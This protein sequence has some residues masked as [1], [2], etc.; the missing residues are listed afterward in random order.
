MDKQ[1]VAI[2][3]GGLGA[4]TT[5]YWLSES[6]QASEKYEITIY[7]QGW[8]LGGKGASGRNQGEGLGQRIEEHG[9]HIWFG[10]YE[11][12]FRTYR[13]VLE[14]LRETPEPKPATYQ[15]WREAFHPHSLVVLGDNGPDGLEQ[16]PI[17]FARNDREPGRGQHPSD[18]GMFLEALQAGMNFFEGRFGDDN[19]IEDFLERFGLP[20]WATQLLWRGERKLRRNFLRTVH[21]A[22]GLLPEDPLKR[23]PSLELGLAATLELFRNTSREVLRKKIGSRVR[24]RR[25]F[26]MTDLLATT[27][28][29]ILRDSLMHRGFESVD[30]LE[31]RQWLKR[32]GAD[33]EHT[34]NSNFTRVLNDLMFAYAGGD[35]QQPNI[36][37]GTAAR[38]LLLALSGY[39]GAFMYKM[40]SGMGDTL[41]VPMYGLLKARGVKFE[42][43]HRVDKIWPDANG[44]IEQIDMSR[45]VRLK[46]AVK[47]AGGYAPLKRVGAYDTWPSTPDFS[48]IINGN[49][50]KQD[51]DN[52]GQPYNLE[53]GWTAWPGAGSRKL[54]RGK[55]FDL[56]VNAIPPAGQETISSALIARSEAWKKMFLGEARVQTTRTQAMQLWMRK[57]P[58]EMGWR[59]P[60][61]MRLAASEGLAAPLLGGYLQPFNTWCD[62]TQLLA[63]EDWGTAGPMSLAYLCGQM[64]DD[65][66]QPPA[67]DHE[68]P[69]REHARVQKTAR[70]WLSNAGPVLWPKVADPRSRYGIAAEAL[71]ANQ[72]GDPFEQQYFRANI[73]ASERYTLSLAGTTASRLPP[74]SQEFANLYLAGDW[75]L[76]P[77]LNAGCVESTVASGMA[78]SRAICGFPTHIEGEQKKG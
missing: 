76:N 27:G 3:G 60:D 69:A 72:A 68:Y 13:Q 34:L 12:A 53:S 20:D 7:Q 2:L 63:N 61:R 77:V 54:R 29:G 66:H 44:L 55:D 45:Q 70:R 10:S 73:D 42:F 33:A 11:N 38:V 78:A 18:W 47:A 32:H 15:D 26:I 49:K 28:I 4:L 59:V 48:Q 65:P 1:K 25:I 50:L 16:W 24:A 46:A 14:S 52:P 23:N 56:V 39:D 30:H 9:L 36:A 31:F 37:A 51:P 75:T 64:R 6:P 41:F 21:K 71:H 19:E 8:R 5:A 74:H 17:L 58:A 22:A 35:E 43:F 62:M 40:E 67:D 57:T